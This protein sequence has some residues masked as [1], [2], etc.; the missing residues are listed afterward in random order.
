MS[1]VQ[2]NLIPYIEDF[3]NEFELY[4]DYMNGHKYKDLLEASIIRFLEFESTYTAHEIYEN[5]FMIYQITEEDKSEEKNNI[6]S[7]HISESNTLLKLVNVMKDY[8]ENTGD[9]IEKQ[10]DHFIHSV[11]VFILGLAI[12]SSNPNYRKTF[13]KY[14]KNS[15][16]KKYYKTKDGKFSPE[17][18]LYRW[19]I[20]SLFHDIGYPVEIIG[21]QLSKFINDSSQSISQK[22][23]VNTTINFKN[24]N[25]MNSIIKVD[26]KFPLIYR[27]DY[28]EANFIDV[29]KPTNIMAHQIFTD[30]YVPKKTK[31][32]DEFDKYS[33]H[34]L[35]LMNHLDNFV[36]YMAEN[37][38]IDHG[39]FSAIFVLNSYGALMQKCYMEKDMEKYAYFFYPILNSATSILLHNYY[40]GTLYKKD[41]E[42]G[43]GQMKP[44]KN[45]LAFL[46][47]FCDEL[48]EWNRK[49]IGV[50]DKKRNHVNDIN[51]NISKDE[52]TVRYMLKNSALGPNFS[53]DKEGLI[54]DLLY[55]K[56]IF[57]NGLKVKIDVDLDKDSPLEDISI[58][59]MDAPT[60]LLR[61]IEEIA[62]ASHAQYNAIEETKGNKITPYDELD[63]KMKLSSIR[64]AKAYP[65]KLN[66][67]GCEIVSK[68]DPRDEHHLT[69]NEVNHLAKEEHDDWMNEKIN[70]G[71]ISHHEAFK[72]KLI[73]KRRYQIMS[74]TN[75][76]GNTDNKNN[77]FINKD[78]NLYVHANLIPF[79]ELNSDSKE[80][81]KRP[82]REIPKILAKI[83][84]NPL[85]IVDTK[86]KLFT[87]KM[88]ETYREYVADEKEIPEF[89]D[90]P[91]ETQYN[92]FK[93]AHLIVKF[94]SE[95]NYSVVD[96]D[97]D[98]DGI[99]TLEEDH[100]EYLAKREHNAWYL[101]KISENFDEE[102]LKEINEAFA[103]D[104]ISE[105]YS[106]LRQWDDLDLDMTEPNIH[107]FE[108]L[109]Q[110]LESV[111]L[112]IIKTK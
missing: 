110:S 51:I 94:L 58:A 35:K 89:K 42:F 65:K 55:L 97:D 33:K 31:A 15:P 6:K 109:P 60:I 18:F 38:F 53:E 13:E 25:E 27:M 30:L 66:L 68:E 11:N 67:I 82:I 12:Y 88:H 107:T 36:D 96:I 78:K 79:E 91:F 23:N 104:D 83:R 45:P 93:Q 5:F 59:E 76:E 61:N 26:P 105:K 4:D 17:E 16:Y 86:L 85:K 111:G 48:Q 37:N 24:F 39:F 54:N 92:N 63:A 32:F 28:P 98:R 90:L 74:E 52:V 44:N 41:G 8:E 99:D 22:Y 3:F 75:K 103:N 112:K 87:I 56:P 108:M 19:G 71:W 50:K 9:L 29:Y 70:T 1:E 100:V 95:L 102:Q 21:K 43:L 34:L 49:P 10:R 72:E 40:R 101:R 80:K 57:S 77:K 20:A 47:I 81:D 7:T 62:R 84:N 2:D 64:Q 106:R 73:T 14:V 46:L 69:E